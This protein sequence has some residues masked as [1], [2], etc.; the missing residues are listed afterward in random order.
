MER[1]SVLIR[2]RRINTVKMFILSKAIYRVNESPIKITMAF[3]KEIGQKTM[4][5]QRNLKKKKKIGGSHSL[6][7]ND[8]TKQ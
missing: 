5:S 6:I 4:N 1:Y 8:I 3:F 2:T 7:S